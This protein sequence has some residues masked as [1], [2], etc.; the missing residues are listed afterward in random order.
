M[1]DV[2]CDGHIIGSLAHTYSEVFA[3]E[4]FVLICALTLIV[5]E[6]DRMAVSRTH[7][8]GPR[9]GVLALG[10]GVGLAIYKVAPAMFGGILTFGSNLS[11]SLGLGAGLLLIWLIWHVREWGQ[12]VPEFALLLVGVTVPHLIITPF[13]DVSSH[14]MYALAPA[15]Y[16]TFVD[17]RFALYLL[18]PM[19]MVFSRPLAGAH[20]WLES[21]GGLLL[22][23]VFLAGL[24]YYRSRTGPG[25]A[26][27]ETPSK[28]VRRI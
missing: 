8:L 1:L 14:V 13:W 21:L 3:P 27:E 28:T 2:S 16:L 23:G 20:T 11:G 12:L 22:A 17:R 6:W 9:L 19:G 25:D 24:R 18:V 7:D 4:Y 5:Y 15:G 10:W 26:D